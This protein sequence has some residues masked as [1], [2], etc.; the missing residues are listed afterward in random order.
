MVLNMEQVGHHGRGA[1][2]RGRHRRPGRDRPALRPAAGDGRQRDEVQVHHQE[3]GAARHGKT[4]T[5]MPKPLFM[6]N[7]SG[8]HCHQCLWK[9]GENLFYDESGYARPQRDGDLLHRRPAEARAGP[10]GVHQPHHQQLPPAGAGLRGAV[11]LVYSQRN[12]SAC[13]RIP[14]YCKQPEGQAHRVPLP[15]PACNPYLAFSAMLMA[16][17]DGIENK[18]MPPAPD[19]QGPLRAGARGAG[20]D[21]AGPGHPGRG[22]ERP[23]GGPPVPAARRRVHPGRDRHL[24]RLQARRRDGRGGARAR[25]RYEFSSTTTRSRAPLVPDHR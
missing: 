1:P 5:F 2:P 24:D 18:I 6:D 9:D 11:N 16:G 22:A 25:T 13:V 4:V 12:R 23:G 10:A 21:Q 19:G 14:M 8:M 15:D 7:G 17:L 3:H 20:R